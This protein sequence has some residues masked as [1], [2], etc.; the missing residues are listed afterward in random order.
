MKQEKF[1]DEM[2]EVVLVPQPRRIVI[3][4][5]LSQRAYGLFDTVT[6]TQV[7]DFVKGNNEQIEFN[8]LEP[9]RHYDVGVIENTGDEK[10]HFAI[11]W[12]ADM[13]DDTNNILKNSVDLPVNYPCAYRIKYNDNNSDDVY[14]LADGNGE[15]V[16]RV[17]KL[18]PRGDKPKFTMVRTFRMKDDTIK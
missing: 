14:D 8:D 16:G 11:N 10:P 2:P 6:G 1:T 13:R 7:S 9:G 3:D 5:T 12:T 18:S 15:I 4:C 17:A